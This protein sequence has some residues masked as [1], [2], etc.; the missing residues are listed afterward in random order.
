M[1]KRG[2]KQWKEKMEVETQVI[3]REKGR[4]NN[5]EKEYGEKRDR[6]DTD[7]GRN[8]RNAQQQKTGKE[9]REYKTNH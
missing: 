5:E 8:K 1:E 4:Q 9:K 7:K 6:E 3:V 2:G